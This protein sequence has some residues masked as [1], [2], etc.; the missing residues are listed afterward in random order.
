MLASDPSQHLES[1]FR[2]FGSPF[3]SYFTLDDALVSYVPG[4]ERRQKGLSVR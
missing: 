1:D 3:D 2:F 4:Q